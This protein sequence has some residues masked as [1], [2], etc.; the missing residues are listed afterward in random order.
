MENKKEFFVNIFGLIIVLLLSIF[1]VFIS[2]FIWDLNVWIFLILI[3]VFFFIFFFYLRN[4]VKFFRNKENN[5]KFISLV[6][7]IFWF[8]VFFRW[9]ILFFM[10]VFR[11]GF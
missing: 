11:N 5:I 9:M 4:T 7:T 2:Y 10:F 8:Y 6:S 3:F 1:L